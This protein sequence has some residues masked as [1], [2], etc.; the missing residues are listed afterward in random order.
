MIKQSQRKIIEILD[1]LP[2]NWKVLDVGGASGPLTRADHV[3]DIV[4]YEAV[5]FTNS[6][7]AGQHRFDKESYTQFD[8]CSRKEWPFADKSFDYVVCS[9]VLEDIRDPLWVC[10]ELIRVSK[11]GYIETPS[12][13]YEST[14]GLEVKGLA[15][16]AHH[17]WVVELIDSK[18]RFTF[19]YFHIHKPQINKQRKNFSKGSLSILGAEW[20]NDFLYFENWLNSGKEIFEFYLGRNI[21]EKEK[22]TFYRKTQGGNAVLRWLKYFKNTN[23]WLKKLIGKR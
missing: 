19:K 16:A 17:R 23:L 7:G 14:F 18:L 6:R 2:A 8:I 1:S 4:P 15:G 9:H 21:S 5:Q 10:S 11:A 3:I 22:W 20:E 12:R 13:L